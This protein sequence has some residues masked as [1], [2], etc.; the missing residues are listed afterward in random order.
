MSEVVIYRIRIKGQLTQDWSD[1]FEGLVIA[2]ESSG[3]TT[4]TGPVRDQ[5]ALFG[6]LYKV[7]DLNLTLISVNPAETLPSAAN[8]TL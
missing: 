1:W 3:D 7:H 6:L 5:A 8:S 2:S 4:L